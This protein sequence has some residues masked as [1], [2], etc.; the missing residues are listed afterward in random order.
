M[1]YEV[2][3]G[4]VARGLVGGRAVE[5]PLAEVGDRLGGAVLE[6]HGLTTETTVTVNPDV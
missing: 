1:T 2:D 5:V 3:I 6:G 4:V